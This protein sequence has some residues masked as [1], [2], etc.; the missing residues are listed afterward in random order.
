M[1]KVCKTFEFEAA[2]ILEETCNEGCKRVH[3]HSYKLEVELRAPS[4]SGGG[5]GMVM[6]FTELSSIVKSHIVDKMDHKMFRRDKDVDVIDFSDEAVVLMA[7]QP[8]AEYMCWVI[9]Q[10]LYKQFGLSLSRVRLWETSKSWAE[11]SV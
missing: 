10:I 8:T 11:Y 5:N 2:H 1:F 4:V 3:G 6:D 9:F 7:K